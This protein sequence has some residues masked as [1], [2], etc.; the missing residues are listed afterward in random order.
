MKTNRTRP[1][2]GRALPTLLSCLVATAL[3]AA[4]GGGG[5]SSDATGTGTQT[6]AM[7]GTVATGQVMAGATVTVKDS[8]GKIVTTTSDANG[9]YTLSPSVLAGLVSP[10][11]IKASNGQPGSDLYSVS[12]TGGTTNVTP[13][14]SMIVAALSGQMPADFFALAGS[15]SKATAL[16]NAT[17]IASARQQVQAALTAA[18]V[19]PTNIGDYFSTPIVVGNA[20]DQV[21]ENTS[22]TLPSLN[23]FIAQLAQAT[24]QSNG[25]TPPSGGTPAS[26][27]VNTSSYGG[28]MTDLALNS[29]LP[30]SV[31]QS[32]LT[33]LPDINARWIATSYKQA[34]FD[35]SG[36]QTWSASRGADTEGTTN[37]AVWEMQPRQSSASFQDSNGPVSVQTQPTRLVVRS[38]NGDATAWFLNLNDYYA[39]VGG[40]YLGYQEHGS[41]ENPA[42]LQLGS[43][44]VSG[45]YYAA[46]Q[47]AELALDVLTG[48]GN[49]YSRIR[50]QL[51]D[52]SKVAWQDNYTVTFSGKQAISTPLGSLNVCSYTAKGTIT[53]ADNSAKVSYQTV[54]YAAPT[55][56]AVRREYSESDTNA[57]GGVTFTMTNNRD[58]VG[59]VVG[60]TNYG[61]S[62]LPDDSTLESCLKSTTLPASLTGSSDTA[63]SAQTLYRFDKDLV[64][65]YSNGVATD[66]SWRNSSQVIQDTPS[67]YNY[68]AAVDGQPTILS[69]GSQVADRYFV[70]GSWTGNGALPASRPA[71][72]NNGVTWA[73]N[74]HTLQTASGT[75]A[76]WG[77]EGDPTNN[78]AAQ[79]DGTYFQ[80]VFYDANNALPVVWLNGMRKN[81]TVSGAVFRYEQNSWL[82]PSGAFKTTL[83]ISAYTYNGRATVTTPLGTFATCKVSSS[84]TQT[85]TG[86][87]YNVTETDV[88]HHVPQLGIV[89]STSDEV[90]QTDINN[91]GQT[92]W[93][94]S[95]IKVLTGKLV[96]GT[97]YGSLTN[98]AQ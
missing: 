20:A 54:I 68:F 3:L 7:T 73:L 11:I 36:N 50:F 58:L 23:A 35:V 39:P 78:P 67:Y 53:K 33:A 63:H 83:Q 30:A 22:A 82:Q 79:V 25:G 86:V 80:R 40:A 74:G 24:T 57:S 21:L 87:S 69:W 41:P 94:S 97:L 65:N 72:A 6:T 93:S 52:K 55:L 29:P 75:P 70:N 88:E 92:T 48:S 98:P 27:S 14:T 34:S 56:G 90:D 44:H 12:A 31:T 26:A 38:S 59:A 47:K 81:E 19:D 66:W 89:Y 64:G 71:G 45:F 91:P 32:P 15:S 95:K 43:D 2:I 49:T 8:N 42:Y 18:G 60:H 76:G 5:G 13:L 84:V 16:I 61:Q 10:L 9:N 37:A 51:G 4:C 96:G 17:T 46:S 85:Q 28:C 77:Q 1:A 62:L